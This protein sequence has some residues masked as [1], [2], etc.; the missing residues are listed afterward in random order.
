MPRIELELPL[1]AAAAVADAAATA[2]ISP[3]ELLT[4]ALRSLP[5]FS[6]PWPTGPST[7]APPLLRLENS[8]TENV[9]LPN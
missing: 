3:D 8:M 4:A 2:G 5:P 9:P 7:T 1:I 6:G